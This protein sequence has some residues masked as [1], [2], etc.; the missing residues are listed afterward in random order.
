[1]FNSSL[2]NALTRANSDTIAG[3]SC[4]GMRYDDLTLAASGSSYVMPDDGFIYLS[5][6]AGSSGQYISIEKENLQDYF[7]ATVNSGTYRINVP[8]NKGETIKIE[9]TTSGELKYFRFYYLKGN[10]NV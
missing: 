10:E 1:M 6:K 4:A 9:Y 7:I 3:Y 2:N 5:K 8:V